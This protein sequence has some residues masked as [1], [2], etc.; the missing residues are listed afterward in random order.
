MEKNGQRYTT[1]TL[2]PTKTGNNKGQYLEELGQQRRL[3]IK[4]RP[5]TKNLH[6]KNFRSWVMHK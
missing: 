6:I 2:T 4:F 3:N 1:A 5:P